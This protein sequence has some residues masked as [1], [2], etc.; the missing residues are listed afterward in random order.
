MPGTLELASPETDALRQQLSALFAPMMQTLHSKAGA[1]FSV[2]ILAED[3]VQDFIGAHAKVLDSAFER[4]PMSDGMRQRLQQSDYIFSGIKT[5][6]ELNE[7]FPSL[8]DANGE[9]KPFEQFLN[10]VRK[11]DSTYNEN[12]LR[13]EYNFVHSSADMASKWEQFEQDGDRYNLQY[14]T[15]GDS[16]VRPEHAALNGV[17]LPPSDPFW[18]TYYPPNGWNCRC[19]VVQVRKTKYP[20]TPHEDAMQRGAQA[21]GK[22][23]KGIF[24][25]NAGQ[26]QKT[27]PDYN[28]YTIKR[29]RDCDI[30][31]GKL[32][33]AFVPENELCDA[34][35]IIRQMKQR[36]SATILSSD[37]RKSIRK[38]SE[39]WASMH[40]ETVTNDFG[41]I[42]NQLII[43]HNR[44]PQGII[45]N[46]SFFGETFAKSNKKRTRNL[47][48]T[49]ELAVQITEWLPKAKYIR[50]EA[51][52]HHPFPFDVY[53]AEVNGTKV[54]CKVAMK[55][56]GA[57]VYTMRIIN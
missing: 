30:A 27:M 42:T 31:K 32:N 3:K 46:R 43:K 22:D 39:K 4:T 49:M 41:Q 14:R 19:T 47:A 8:V 33:L 52:K 2:D 13:A 1:Q 44:M 10:D 23:T 51:G 40:L 34:C 56:S 36:E 5:F 55:Y 26:Q 6:H 24:Q 37:E 17:T 50:T 29:C 45:L 48:Q 28:P 35:R 21:T 25:F 12:Y 54:E 15:A 16:K 38:A 9:R 57:A 18:Q 20:V 11:I 53:E 7:A